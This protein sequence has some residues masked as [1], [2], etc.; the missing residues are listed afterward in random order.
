MVSLSTCYIYEM[1]NVN[2]A[3]KGTCSCEGSW[4]LANWCF[5]KNRWTTKWGNSFTSLGLNYLF[6]LLL[7]TLCFLCNLQKWGSD[8]LAIACELGFVGEWGLTLKVPNGATWFRH[9]WS[10]WS[11]RLVNWSV[12]IASVETV[13]NKHPRHTLNCFF[14]TN[15][16]RLSLYF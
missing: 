4:N 15:N 6:F 14:I 1:V 12:E 3:H 8:H 5:E 7:W 11:W 9:P 10:L 13:T 16:R 2:Q